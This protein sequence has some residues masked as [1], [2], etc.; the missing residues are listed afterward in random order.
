[1]CLCIKNNA[2]TTSD[3]WQLIEVSIFL[4]L[5]AKLSIAVSTVCIAAKQ[6]TK[7]WF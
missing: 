3:H 7:N 6:F 5:P 2:N 1:M 4:F